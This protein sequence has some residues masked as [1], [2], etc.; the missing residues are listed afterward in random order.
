MSGF[1]YQVAPTGTGIFRILRDV[2]LI[3]STYGD[4]RVRVSGLSSAEVIIEHWY[5]V[6]SGTAVSWAASRSHS[7]VI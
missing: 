6:A 5:H 3:V 1:E 4:S 7:V 2:N